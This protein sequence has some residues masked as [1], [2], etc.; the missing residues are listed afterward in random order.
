MELLAQSS[1]MDMRVILMRGP[2]PHNGFESD[3][4]FFDVVAA[5]AR[6]A[7]DRE[8]L[9]QVAS[10]YRSLAQLNRSPAAQSRRDHWRKRAE[11]CRTLAEQFRNRTCRA[12]LTRLA[13]TYELM[14]ETCPDEGLPLGKFLQRLEAQVD[15]TKL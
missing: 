5:Q 11:E 4:A 13:D 1:F 3:A 6:D 15:R 2:M 9:R 8:E 12:Q 14:A 7:V 10:T